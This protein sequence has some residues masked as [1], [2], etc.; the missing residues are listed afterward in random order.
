[1]K[2]VIAL[3]D[4]DGVLIQPG[5]Y[6]SAYRETL[7]YFLYK[8]NLEHLVPD[9]QIP[10]LFEA[11]GVTSEWDMIPITLAIALDAACSQVQRIIPEID[12]QQ[13]LVMLQFNN[14][15]ELAVD[16]DSEIRR[17][18]E[19][20]FI[21]EIP[22]E[23]LLQICLDNNEAVIFPHLAGVG[24]RLLLEIFGSSRLV[25]Q[26]SITRIFQNIILGDEVFEYTY[27]IPAELHLSSYL[28]LYDRP[29]I[30]PLTCNHLQRLSTEKKIYLA[31]YTARPSLPP[32][33]TPLVAN[34]YSPEAEM[35]LSLLCFK[36]IPL[37]GLGKVAYLAKQLQVNP[38]SL[39][40]P[41]PIQALAAIAA[42]WSV[43]EWLSLTWA[44][45]FYEQSEKQYNRLTKL[46]EGIIGRNDFPGAL[47]IHIFED[48]PN[49]IQAC[50]E[51]TVILNNIGIE[52]KLFA[53][54]IAQNDD[55]KE[56]LKS[57]GA[58]IFPSVDLA[59]QHAFGN[60][61]GA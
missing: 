53:W 12:L 21:K 11:H 22:S 25:D 9:D 15:Y 19:Y 49:G 51:A 27:D 46:N 29:L 3:F 60:V 18:S 31:A 43:K 17:L 48:S 5:G 44:A 45:D 37:I 24:R 34:G 4:I 40:K 41:S 59:I 23:S 57:M 13:L 39:L 55:K 28:E 10:E 2:S 16:Y 47:D 56:V 26:S 32:I 61:F 1:M 20:Y 33:E 6:R 58:T 14:L 38:D 36:D 52:A 50:K 8:A 35:A 7:K 54:G 30:Q 42:A